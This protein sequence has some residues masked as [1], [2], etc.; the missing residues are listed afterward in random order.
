MDLTTAR[1]RK[2]TRSSNTSNCVELART[3]QAAAIRDSKNPTGPTLTLTT[4]ALT[5]FLTALKQ[6]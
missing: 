5:S 3:A 6:H 2:S 4:K 1:W